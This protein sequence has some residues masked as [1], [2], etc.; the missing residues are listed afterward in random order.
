MFQLIYRACRADDGSDWERFVRTGGVQRRATSRRCMSA[1]VQALVLGV[2][3][4]GSGGDMVVGGVR[5]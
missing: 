5:W 3:L 1:L 4:V 2:G